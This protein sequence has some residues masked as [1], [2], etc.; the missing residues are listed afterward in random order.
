MD[1]HSIIA[2]VG[3]PPG[4]SWRGMI[5]VSGPGAFDLLRSLVLSGWPSKSGAVKSGAL[6]AVASERSGAE[7]RR[8][9]RGIFR[10]RLRE[11]ALGFPALLLVL[12]A[13]GSATGD[14]TFELL[15]PGNP[16]FLE[17]LIDRLVAL[18][19][20]VRRAGPGEFSLR[21]FLNGRMTLDA[22]EGVAALIRAA[23]DE[24]L[25]AAQRLSRGE[26]A[27]RAERWVSRL[28]EAL[29]LIEAGIDF[30]DEEDVVAIAPA[31]L[32]ETVR[33]LLHELDEGL[34]APRS[35]TASS[36]RARRSLEWR[37]R[38]VL[39][40]KPNAGK[41]TLFNALIGRRRSV[42]SATVGTTR[43]AVEVEV[44]VSVAGSSALRVLLTDLPGV[45]APGAAFDTDPLHARLRSAALRAVSEADLLLHCVP[46][47]EEGASGAID[48][49]L[50]ASVPILM[51]QT[52]CDGRA[53]GGAAPSAGAHA[54]NKA[55]PDHAMARPVIDGPAVRPSD[56]PTHE[57]TRRVIRTS[58]HLGH[59]LG[60]L[61][62]A[63]A[64]ALADQV[65]ALQG[66][67]ALLPRHAA[68]LAAARQHLEE[69]AELAMREPAMGPWTSPERVAALLRL[70]LDAFGQITGAT[71]PDDVLA[72][73][74]SRFCIGK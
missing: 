3:S 73:I 12:S 62:S 63:I 41:S 42:E 58:A 64:L 27:R 28:I 49:V 43:D 70:A 34:H 40:G 56:P 15:L 57:G 16:L 68:A 38:V 45:D 65:K 71:A 39:V 10:V 24:S 61:R 20:R 9:P 67:A 48:E 44:E 66:H 30:T 54:W 7:L 13:P 35:S 55:G 69:C 29:A 8:W 6:P 33:V 31:R 19:A 60:E 4:R 50:S 25:H 22:A 52:K 72:L 36:G 46:A 37:P 18:D 26:L 2:A 23:D 1:R 21:A 32:V 74:F 14:D 53:G 59:G 17:G 47:G 51:V 11:P 5:R